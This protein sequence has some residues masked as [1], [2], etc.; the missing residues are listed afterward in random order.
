[1]QYIKRNISDSQLSVNTLSG[2]FCLSQA[3]LCSY[4][5]KETQYTI[6]QYITNIRI[7]QAKYLLSYTNDKIYDIALKIGFCD[8]NYFSALFKKQ[9]GITPLEY[10]KGN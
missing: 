7:E 10:R 3:Y 5:K 6:N 9:V 8:T 4:F 2:A 1:V